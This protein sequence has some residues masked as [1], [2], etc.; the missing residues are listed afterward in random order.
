MIKKLIKLIR[1]IIL[2][3][4][5]VGISIFIT[6]FINDNTEKGE[7]LTNLKERAKSVSETVSKDTGIKPTIENI[8]LTDSDGNKKNY[9]FTYNGET[10]IAKHSKNRW[11]ID[12]SYKITNAKDIEII[13]QALI[14]KYPILGK[15]YETY[16][17]AQDMAYE[18]IQHNIAYN[19]LSEDNKYKDNAKDVDFNPEDQGKNFKDFYE[20]RTGKKFDIKNID[21]EKYIKYLKDNFYE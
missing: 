20:A 16:R 1:F 7:A 4:I 6:R 14:E 18:W 9:S 10:F 8:E 11:H 3:A 17:T 12:D 13:C 19:L 21:Y 5:L 2:I 15:D